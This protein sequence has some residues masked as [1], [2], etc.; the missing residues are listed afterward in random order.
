MAFDSIDP[1]G[2]DRGD[3]QAGIIASTVANSA[4]AKNIS[5]Q[6][7][8]YSDFMP[9]ANKPKPNPVKKFR[10]QMA[11]LIKKKEV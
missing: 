11:H 3:M 9:F 2:M 1:I 7:F 10:A 5:G 8:K 6:Q 4:G